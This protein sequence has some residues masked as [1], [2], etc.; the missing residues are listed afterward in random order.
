MVCSRTLRDAL[1]LTE[2][3]S[4]AAC[5]L[6]SKQIEQLFSNLFSELSKG[7]SGK[8]V[9]VN[10]LQHSLLTSFAGM[11]THNLLAH[12]HIYMGQM[13]HFSAGLNLELGLL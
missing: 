6:L 3:A 12:S 1:H 11:I 2:S 8:A 7:N 9:H 10:H 5:C 4:N 13:V